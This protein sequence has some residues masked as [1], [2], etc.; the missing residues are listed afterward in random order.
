M[1][2]KALRQ[3]ILDLAIR[4]KLVPQDPNDEP[5]SVLLEKIRAEKQQMVKEGK[6]KA[7]DIKNDTIIFKGEDNLHYEKF[8]DGTVKCIEDEIPF[9]VPEGWEWCRIRNLASVK[10]GKRLPKGMSFSDTI[11]EHAYIR[12]T[13]MKNRSINTTGLKYISDEVFEAI[14]A[15]TISKNDLYVTIA[16][17]IGVVGEVPDE[18]DGMNLTENAVKVCD[19]SINKTYLCYVM[20]SRFVQEQFQDKT[21]QVAMPKLALERILSTLIPIAPIREQVKLAQ[22][23]ENDIK[24]VDIID[25]NNGELE[26]ALSNTKSKILDLAIRGKLVP[27]DP[28]DEPASVLLERIRAEKEELIKQGKIKRDKKESIIFKG[29]DNSY[30]ET[31]NGKTICIDDEL[32][33]ELPEGWE[34]SRLGSL[35]LYKKGPFGSSLTKAMFV[36]NSP[37]AV[38]IYEQKNAINKDATLGGYYIS[39][40]KYESLRGFEVF[41]NDI[42]VSCAG[43]IGE[44]Y[45][46]PSNIRKGIINQALMKISLFDLNILD[47]YLLYFDFKLKESAQEHSHGI[48][49]KNIPP[50][51]VIKHYLIPIP[52][53]NEQQRIIEQIKKLV[54]KLEIISNALS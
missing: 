38:K 22:A 46:M 3:K 7:K 13:D 40:E 54:N 28:N 6:L 14:K 21:H 48:A 9:E 29:D 51:D 12:V 30:Y 11:T 34:W 49:L 2:T 50:F 32:P 26:V 44:S 43:T 19:I 8:Q 31:F 36:P 10:G 27:Q 4:G 47:F 42:I 17:T 41:P 45:V 25:I 18:L 5:A 33:F 52:P 16:G 1:D 15:Y 24:L 53:L 37:S 39:E 23:I 20:L 35:A